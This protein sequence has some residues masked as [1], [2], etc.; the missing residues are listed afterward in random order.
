MKQKL[1]KIKTLLVATAL[2]MGVTSAW[3]EEANL[4]P[5][6]DTYFNWGDAAA[7]YGSDATL[8]CGVWQ[9]KYWTDATPGLKANSN[10]TAKIAVF[11]FDVSAYKGKI[12]SATFKVTGT[13]PSTNTNTRSIYLGYFDLTDWT[14][15][16]TATTCGMVTR[17]A[18]NLNIHPFNLS[19]AIAKGETKEV[20][21]SSDDFLAYLNGDED[22]IVSLIIYGVG[23]EITVNSKEADSGQPSLEL[24]YSNETLYTATFTETNALTPAVTIYSDSERTTP[25]TNG[26]LT[27]GTTYYYTA[28][29]EG[30]EDIL[31]SFTVSGAAPSI[32]LT[33]AAKPR[34]TFTVCAVSFDG[35]NKIL[36]EDEDSWEG[37]THNIT[38][39]KYLADPETHEVTYMMRGN[40][41][42]ASYVAKAADET[43]EVEYEYSPG[44]V[45]AYFFE[46]EEF[47]WLGTQVENGNYS[48]GKAA[49]GLN[50]DTKTVFTAPKAGIYRLHYALCNNNTN[51]E[52]TYAF[53]KNSS[54]NVLATETSKLWS[55]NYVKSTGTKYLDNIALE[56]GDEIQFFA[57]NTNI[58]LDWVYIERLNYYSAEVTDAGW[59]TL[60]TPY[61]LDFTE[62]EE[63]GLTAYTA[64]CDGETVTLTKVTNVPANTG[65]VLKGEGYT[66]YIPVIASSTTARG[67]LKG[68]ATEDT[69]YDKFDEE[70]DMYVLGMNGENEAQFFL[71][72]S[73]TVPSGKAYL[74]IRQELEVRAMNVVINETT[75]IQ[76]IAAEQAQTGIFTLSGQRVAK[77]LTGNAS[78]VG[79]K[80]GL[81]IENGKKVVVK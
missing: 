70:Y 48:G 56:A 51:N 39:S 4:A 16:S 20:S 78:G 13:N 62:T 60:Y 52:C 3:A 33:M 6:A 41:F 76:T 64:T 73:G 45:T 24:T 26:T 8:S 31:G 77:A 68:S 14:E 37:K 32:D 69:D 2:T 47:D 72:T 80:K 22:G 46:G 18:T 17:H 55:V 5:S 44:A 57:S 54:E 65:V 42:F 36:Y 23:Q 7:A 12:T 59:A 28:S 43:K 75:A 63:E 29:L 34:Y 9:D 66:Y 1:L 71:A 10:A 67:D 61:P 79:L 81:Y 19:Q 30:Y 49:R 25:V 74:L 50:N 11:K 21:F 53:Y 15:E 27:D 35:L 58:I 38:F 40:N